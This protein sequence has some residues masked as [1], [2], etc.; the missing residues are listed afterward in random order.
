MINKTFRLF[1]SSTFSDFLTERSILNEEVFPIIDYYCQSQGYNFQLIDLRWG[2]NNESALN[3]NTLDI[4]LD[5]VKRCRTLSPKPNF[6][7]MTGERYGWIPLPATISKEDFEAIIVVASAEEYSILKKWYIYDENEIGG[8]YYL[9]TRENSFI[10][11]NVWSAEEARLHKALISCA[12]KNAGFPIET[13][14]KLT[15]SATEQEILEGLLSSSDMS[16]NAIAIFRIGYPE[17]DSDQSK[18]DELKKR[19]KEKMTEDGCADNVFEL[20]WNDDYPVNFKKIIILTLKKNIAKE[21]ERLEAESKKSTAYGSLLQQYRENGVVVERK[22]E[23]SALEDYE[24]GNVNI[25]LYIIGDSGSGKSTL[26]A[27]YVTSRTVDVFYLFYGLDENSYMLVEGLNN[28]AN[29]IKQK[30]DIAYGTSINT[31]NI[32]ESLYE[33]V[34]NIPEDKKVIIVVDGLD[35]FHD[36]NDIHEAV[37][38]AILPPNV[39]I[40][41]SIANGEI[42]DRFLRQDYNTLSI[43]EFS[44]EESNFVFFTF[45]KERNRQISCSSQSQVIV[46]AIGNGAT[47]LQLKLMTEICTKWRSSDSGNALPCIVDEVALQHLTDMYTKFG[48]NKELVLYALALISSSPYGITE[49]ELQLL[50]LKFDRVKKYFISEDRFNHSLGKL[51]FVIWSRLFYDL[52][53]CLTLTKSNGFIIV[54]FAH[55]IF[56]RVFTKFYP[57]YC[58]QAQLV[59]E[60][61]FS[62]QDSFGE[63][64]MPNV[65]KAIVLP[66]L[67][68]KQNKIEKLIDLY[69]DFPFLDST[70]KSGQVDRSISNIQFIIKNG[71]QIINKNYYL[72]LYNCLQNN[73][74]MLNCYYDGF[75]LCAAEVGLFDNEIPIEVAKKSESGSSLFFPYSYNSQVTWYPEGNK[76]AVFYRSYV[77]ICDSS[78]NTELCRIFIQRQIDDKK[79]RIKGVVWLSDDRIAVCAYG[80]GIYIY[81]VGDSIPNLLK[82]HE[83]CITDSSRIKCSR[84]YS[85]LFLQKDNFLVAI[86]TVNC[87]Q[88]YAI[89]LVRKANLG[90]DV[91]DE[92]LYLKEKPGKI[93]VFNIQTGEFKNY[94]SA[95]SRLSYYDACFILTKRYNLSNIQRVNDHIWFERDEFSPS[96]ALYDTAARTKKYIHPPFYQDASELVCG[97]SKL[98]IV[99]TNIIVAADLINGT[100]LSYYKLENI[101]SVSWITEDCTLSIITTDGLLSANISDFCPFPPDVDRCLV[102]SKT[103]FNTMGFMG[104][105][106]VGGVLK[107]K[108]FLKLFLNSNNLFAYDILFSDIMESYDISL[109]TTGKEIDKA[110]VVAQ[111]DDGKQAVVFEAKNAIYIYNEADKLIAVIDRLKLAL[112]NN[113]MKIS[114]SQNSRYLLLWCNHFIKVFDIKKAKTALSVNL[115]KRPALDMWIDSSSEALHVILCNQEEYILYLNSGKPKG[116]QM[117]KQLVDIVDWDNNFQFWGPYNILPTE[118]KKDVFALLDDVRF[119]YDFGENTTLLTPHR[120]FKGINAYY[121]SENW[122]LYR[123]GE[124]YL[125]GD[126]NS[127]FAHNYADFIKSH[128]I[129]Q[130]HDASP[131][132]SYLRE[133]NDLFSTLYEFGDRHLVLVSRQLNSIIAF[134]IK[135][136][137]VVSAFKINGN[138]IGC[139]TPTETS[140]ELI[141]DK[142]PYKLLFNINLYD[143]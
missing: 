66:F 27:E 18:I 29:Q 45:L 46:N 142:E 118:E 2:V 89:P 67:L 105:K 5:E 123:D 120:W 87:E 36:I 6:L 117:P 44:K 92:E 35:M 10:D 65:R 93:S 73:R 69:N 135:T 71:S 115:L 14:K 37:F 88:Q 57:D 70:V 113:I 25:P 43:E 49:E 138:I 130:L 127:P 104:K 30:Y 72:T 28:L 141:V 128:I 17:K 101:K 108:P 139:F 33:I 62:N 11:D 41:V 96:L 100:K 74:D 23:F 91:L 125:N 15:S 50:L 81:D 24:L 86:N 38:P 140:I 4:C 12:S 7:L 53:G 3:Q 131:L 85:L 82:R 19:I 122:L 107:F 48:H 134:D 40:I 63:S 61:Y 95:K 84:K 22:K 90:F 52:K 80:D 77:Y 51:P 94:I 119:A 13:K 9:K 109:Y 39:K 1:I 55:N 143:N 106:L 129:E 54:K 137:T 79:T 121:A 56:Y 68:K 98:L 97:R 59:L 64:L 103:I 60:T 112:N 32:T 58:E 21:I 99:K 116:K 20:V 47:P 132:H 34:K 75:K 114:F 126:T 16:D 83:C 8:E 26:L 133:K 31:S 102:M 76:Y 124:F 110:S 111:S 78:T 136:L 42:A